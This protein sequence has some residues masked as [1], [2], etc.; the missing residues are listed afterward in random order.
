MESV[1]GKISYCYST[2]NIQ[3]QDI[4]KLR[5]CQLRD[6]EKGRIYNESLAKYI[7]YLIHWSFKI[8][9]KYGQL[10]QKLT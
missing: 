3:L 1:V 5:F 2:L 8:L 6:W 9:N 10:I 7:H 4:G